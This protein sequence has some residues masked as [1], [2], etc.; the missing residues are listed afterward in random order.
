MKMSTVQSLPMQYGFLAKWTG[1]QKLKGGNLWLN[2]VRMCV[3][4]PNVETPFGGM[5]SADFLT[6]TEHYINL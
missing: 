1:G 3:I 4:M 6:E 2:G 5:F